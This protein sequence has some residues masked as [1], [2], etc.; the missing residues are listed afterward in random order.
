MTWLRELWDAHSS[1]GHGPRIPNHPRNR[2][3]EDG[4]EKK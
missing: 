1:R 3:I 4:E 2:L